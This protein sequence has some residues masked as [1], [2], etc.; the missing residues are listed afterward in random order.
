MSSEAALAFASLWLTYLI[1]SAGAYL[2]LWVLCRLIQNSHVRFRLCGIFLGGMVAAWLG[3]L[4]L[5]SPAALFASDSVRLPIVAA[6]HWS[7]PLN[8][9]LVPLLTTVLSRAPWVYVAVLTL[10]FLQFCSPFWQL[11]AL[12]RASQPPSEP[13]SFLFESIRS[14]TKARRCELRLVPGLRSPAATGWWRP[15][16]LLPSELLHRLEAQQLVYVLRHEL[17]HVRRRDYLWDRLATLGCY[18]IFFHPSAWL[19]RRRLRWEREL[20]CDDCVVDRS[21][22]RRLEYASC[23]T[24]LASWWFLEEEIAGPVDFLSSPPS[25]LAAR[26]RALVSRKTGP[27]SS[28]KKAAVG[29]LATT[30]LS[31]MVW[32]MPEIAVTFSRSAPRNAAEIQRFPRSA[33]TI[34]RTNRKQISKRQKLFASVATSPALDSRSAPPDLEFPINLPVLPSPSVVP[35]YQF[36][37]PAASGSPI[38]SGSSGELNAESRSTGPIWDE[39]LPPHTPPSRRASKIATV[40]ARAV[41][42]GVGLVG[43]RTGGH[44]H[45]KEP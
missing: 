27:Y 12:L 28:Y 29:L 5:P 33:R 7:W 21:S 15:K 6:P 43:L 4:L 41:R 44:E 18:L 35:N 17:M 34:A 25:L 40:A 9:A 13:L 32:L 11:R 37:E 20:V 8:S 10:L 14:G 22:E 39:S 26:V 31:L 45:E 2:L 1:R 42:F 19:V 38:D 23:L 24:T 3:L 36:T 30:A 16:V